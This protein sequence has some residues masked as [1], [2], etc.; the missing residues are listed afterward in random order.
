MPDKNHS[1]LRQEDVFSFI[2]KELKTSK[3]SQTAVFTQKT[4]KNFSTVVLINLIALII[5]SAGFYAVYNI[6]KA[7]E[8][9]LI[10]TEGSIKGL[11]D[12]LYK[13]LQK[14]ASA[15]LVKKQQELEDTKSKLTALNSQMDSFK[16]DQQKLLKDQ[17]DKFQAAQNARMQDELKN[18]S[19]IEKEAIR[20]KYEDELKTKQLAL[21]S[22]A[23]RREKDLQLKLEQ[24]KKNLTAQSESREQELK[25]TKVQLDK[26][27]ND[28]EQKLQQVKTTSRQEI[29]DLNIK[30]DEKQKIEAFYDQVNVLFKSA[31]DA[32]QAKD[33]NTARS[34]LGSITTLYAN[35]PKDIIISDEKKSIDKFFIDTINDYLALKETGGKSLTVLNI[36][37][38][39]LNREAE[40]LFNSG[41][42]SYKAKAYDAAIS[43]FQNIIINYSY[44][45]YNKDSVNYLQKSLEMKYADTISSTDKKTQ[46]SSADRLLQDAA[47]DESSLNYDSAKVKYKSIIIQYPL[48]DYIQ[49]ALEGIERVTMAQLKSENIILNQ[50]NQSDKIVGRVVDYTSTVAGLYLDNSEGISVGTVVLIYRKETDTHIK[51][52]GEAVITEI[53]PIV[54]KAKI[55]KSS[56]KIRLGDLIYKK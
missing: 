8:Y 19:K 31:M 5:A 46:N 35:K 20:K 21:E 51:Y 3:E 38:N 41:I 17:Y 45:R 47:R 10:G 56:Q 53:T 54:T 16:K 32:Y 29:A 52:I 30:L 43:K 1:E 13:E 55:L 36:N 24:E 11:D 6:F 4:K 48:S 26:A 27:N 7:G 40:P 9:K 28:F 37:T 2:D 42:T 14:K 18:A 25:Q 49:K 44:S 33:F 39:E 22:D 50:D 34:K 23:I 12:V 15:D